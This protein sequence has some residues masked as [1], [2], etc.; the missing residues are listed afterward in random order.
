MILVSAC[1][2]GHKTKYDGGSNPNELLLKYNE[3]GR[4]IAICPECFGQMP[5]PHPPAEIVKRTNKKILAGKAIVK[6]KEGQEVTRFFYNGADKVLKIANAY[7]VKYAILKESS[8]SCGVHDIYDGS[9][10]GKKVKGNGICAAILAAHG[11]TLYS[12][13]DLNVVRL[14]TLL[15]EDEKNGD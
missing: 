4:F 9:F 11:I 7:N 8:P 1:L 12:E 13:K 14:E 3:R 10:T 5:V 15:L 2:L 6:N